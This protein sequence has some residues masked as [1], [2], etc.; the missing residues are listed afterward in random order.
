MSRHDLCGRT[1]RPRV[2]D[3]EVD[4]DV[5]RSFHHGRQAL[6]QPR[7]AVV[8]DDDHRDVGH[9]GRFHRMLSIAAAGLDRDRHMDTM[10]RDAA[11][12]VFLSDCWISLSTHRFSLAIGG[13]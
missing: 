9:H 5:A 6:G 12:G 10:G 3:D 11:R 7:G 13:S 8:R 1:G 2:D 4:V